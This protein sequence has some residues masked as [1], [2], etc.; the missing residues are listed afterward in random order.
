[1]GIY[2][3]IHNAN[4][5]QL[6]RWWD[7][8]DPPPAGFEDEYLDEVAY[9]LSKAG[10]SGVAALHSSLDAEDIQR[11]RAAVY[12]LAEPRFFDE[13]V[14]GALLRAF[15]SA[16]L[17]LKTAALWGFMHLGR[18]PLGRAEVARLMRRRD[19][20]IAALAMCYLSRAFPSETVTILRV[21]LRSRN[22]RMREYAC[23]EIGD[24][25]ISELSAELRPLLDDRDEYVA[26]SAQSN[27]A[28]F[29]EE[30]T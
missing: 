18:F 15:E 26:Q 17:S 28:F 3:P 5:D 7:G 10:P 13:E 23:D 8:S 22:P 27:L 11:R 12:F 30:A 25:G 4:L 2:D 14:H 1:M 6:L 24:R 9:A 20:R 21:G 19:E 16:D 29:P